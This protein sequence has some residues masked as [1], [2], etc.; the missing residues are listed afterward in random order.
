MGETDFPFQREL[1]SSPRYKLG[2]PTSSHD[3]IT[4]TRFAFHIKKL[5]SQ[6]KYTKKK[7]VFRDWTLIG[8]CDKGN[9]QDDLSF[10][11]GT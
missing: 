10:I 2:K 3:R 8:F 4:M 1:N 9:K 6:R 7:N 11:I 5:E